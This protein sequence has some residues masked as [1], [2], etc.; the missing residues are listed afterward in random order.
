MWMDYKYPLVL[1]K[2]DGP[3]VQLQGPITDEEEKYMKE[4]GDWQERN[5][6]L[7]RED[8]QSWYEEEEYRA[9]KAKQAGYPN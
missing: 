7:P 9:Y 4:A 5:W 1:P 2:D 6:N 8:R 3:S